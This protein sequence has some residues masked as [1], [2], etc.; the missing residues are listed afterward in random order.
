M[1][2]RFQ[3]V[4]ATSSANF[5]SGFKYPNVRRGRPLRLRWMRSRS[6]FECFERSVPLGK[7]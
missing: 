1:A 7:Y 3:P 5:S 6:F 4:S 2:G